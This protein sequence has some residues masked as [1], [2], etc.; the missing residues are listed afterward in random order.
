MAWGVWAHH[1]FSAGLGPVADAVFSLTTMLI[2]VPTGVK[3]F[4]WIGTLHGGSLN[5]KTPLYFALG[6]IFLF[7]IGGLSGV[8][9][10]SPPA[11]WVEN[12]TYFVVAHIHYVLFGGTIFGLFAGIYYWFPKV[13]GRMLD[14]T[15]GKIHFWLMFIGMNVTFAFQHVLGIDGMPRRIYTYPEGMGWDLWNLVSS[16]GAFIIGASIL[17]FVYNVAASLRYGARAGNDP[18]DGRTLEWAIPSPPPEYNF[19]VIPT[20]RSRD[21]FWAMKY[22][23]AGHGHA[24]PVPVAGGAPDHSEAGSQGNGAYGEHED[25]PLHI[26]LP[27]PS[28]YPPI[29]GLGLTLGLAGLLLENP[30]APFPPSWLSIVGVL[31]MAFGIYGWAL[32]PVSGYE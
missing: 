20:V 23:E 26:H 14:E 3:I 13:T 21:P 1:M 19:A 7:I 25:V 12:D 32:E 28:I 4:N 18:W 24:A 31:V 16:I 29:A 22:P 2:A 6:F 5:M 10:A 9:L 8:M 15:F 30:A 17:V 27:D 11:D